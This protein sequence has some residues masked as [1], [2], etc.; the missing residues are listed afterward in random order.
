MGNSTLLVLVLIGLG[1]GF[2]GGLMGLG[3]AIILIPAMVLF[4]S[5]DQRMAQGTAIAV[6]LP[7]IGLLAIVN[8]YKAGYVNL[9]YALIIALFFMLGSY[10]G[11]RLAL[12]IP[13]LLM[14][15]IFAL[16]LG[17]IAAKMFFTR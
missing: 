7:P 11:S 15:K 13:I 1:A 4:L 6:M 5:M 17:L 14:R 16:L 12:Q 3:G 9:K 8:Y 10:F 2:L